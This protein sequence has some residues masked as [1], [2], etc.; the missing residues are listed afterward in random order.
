MSA[1]I[2]NITSYGLSTA[3]IDISVPEEVFR[4]FKT[5]KRYNEELADTFPNQ[6]STSVLIRRH[7]QWKAIKLAGAFAICDLSDTITASHYIDAIRFCE[8]LAH[9]MSLFEYDL[10]KADHERFADFAHTRPKRSI[11]ASSIPTPMTAKS[12]STTWPGRM[13]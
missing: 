12:S 6:T 9:D 1:T 13:A 5:Y 4:L 7:L 11:P 10:N 2:N 8:L 3:G